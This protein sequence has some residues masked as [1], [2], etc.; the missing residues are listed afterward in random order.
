MR[1]PFKPSLA[2]AIFTDEQFW[3]PVVV[4]ALGILFLVFVDKP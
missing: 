4:L 2:K 1:T 3:V